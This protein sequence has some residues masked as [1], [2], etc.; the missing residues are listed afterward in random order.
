MP[1]TQSEDGNVSVSKLPGYEID[2]I[3]S[4]GRRDRTREQRIET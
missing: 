2:A 4:E 1:K 3:Q